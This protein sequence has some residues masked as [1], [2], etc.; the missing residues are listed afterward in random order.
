[1]VGCFISQSADLL[2]QKVKIWHV[3]ELCK[4]PWVLWRRGIEP[5]PV[6]QGRKRF[7]NRR[8]KWI[9]RQFLHMG[10]GCSHQEKM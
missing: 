6:D 2:Q 7:Y 3:S 10:S 9:W 1:M 8:I 5:T 4:T